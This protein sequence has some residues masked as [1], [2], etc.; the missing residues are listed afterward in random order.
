MV[1]TGKSFLL[2]FVDIFVSTAQKTIADLSLSQFDS[3]LWPLS[4]K[5]ACV[6]FSLISL[7]DTSTNKLNNQ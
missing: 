4:A 2:P 5:S 6:I 3:P 1:K 7:I